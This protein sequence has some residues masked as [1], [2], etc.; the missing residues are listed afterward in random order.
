MSFYFSGQLIA[1]PRCM[2]NAA[3]QCIIAGLQSFASLPLT[4]PGKRARPR[5]LW[6]AGVTAIS[7]ALLSAAIASELPGAGE[8]QKIESLTQPRTSLERT[9]E[10][11]GTLRRRPK[12]A[13]RRANANCLRRTSLP[14]FAEF[15]RSSGRGR[16]RVQNFI[17]DAKGMCKKSENISKPTVGAFFTH[18]SE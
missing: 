8:R 18:S 11:F 4:K 9:Y 10:I 17:K 2:P 14:L 12:A 16:R 13:S 5:L 1:Q 3:V 7:A 15:S 6:I